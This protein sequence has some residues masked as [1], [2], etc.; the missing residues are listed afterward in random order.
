MGNIKLNS[1]GTTSVKPEIIGG[2]F[3]INLVPSADRLAFVTEL[4]RIAKNLGIASNWLL[5][6]MYK[7][8]TIQPTARNIQDGKLIAGGLIQ[9]VNRTAE[10]LGY[11]LSTI[12]KM[13]YLQQLKLVEKYYLPYKGKIKSYADLYMVTFF[14]AALNKPASFIF[15]TSTLSRAK[16]AKQNKALDYG[17]KGYITKADFAKYV[18]SNLPTD[19]LKLVGKNN[20]GNETQNAGSNL[21][22]LEI[23]AKPTYYTFALILGAIALIGYNYGKR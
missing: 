1:N 4:N 9:F 16:I 7:E 21:P 23:T 5:V 15:E 8:S 22:G 2:Y 12:L 3:G 20:Q 6:V 18:Y 13:G 19:V 11:N 14:P 10:G 17:N